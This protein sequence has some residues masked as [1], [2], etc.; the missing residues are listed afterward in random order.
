MQRAHR[1]SRPLQQMPP[2]HP[3]NASPSE[4]FSPLSAK[5]Y[6]SPESSHRGG[7]MRL[8]IS[9]GLEESSC[10]LALLS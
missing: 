5:L 10:V 1:R 8:A 7:A 2:A 6:L 3:A 9:A 4:R